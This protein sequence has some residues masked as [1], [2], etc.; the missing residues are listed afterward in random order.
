MPKFRYPQPA[1]SEITDERVWRDRRRLMAAGALMAGGAA[2]PFGRARSESLKPLPGEPSPEFM[3][4]AKITERVHATTYNNFYE[5]GMD[6]SD[7]ERYA[8][9]MKVSP[10]TVRVEG[11]VGKPGTFGIEELLKLEPMQER[12]Y[13][14][15]CV[16]GW[17]MVIPWVGYPLSALLKRVEPTSN[18]KYVEFITDMQPEA[19]P[20][21]S[22]SVIDWPYREG[23]RM[24]EAMN[25]LTL[26][27]FG[28]Y[29]EVLPNQN[30]APVRVIIPW[31]YG[32]KSGKSI[33]TIRLTE[34]QPVSSWMRSA[35]H[36]YGFYANVN[37]EV[38]H[39]RWSQR[40]ERVIGQGLF[41]PRRQTEKF[42]GYQ[43]QVASMYAGM[44]LSKYY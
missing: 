1:P 16:E 25:D 27:T 15:R 8:S 19:M 14:L 22:S 36:E 12:I 32:F 40:T 35:P 43:E 10:W 7:P 18:A 34:K 30:G 28:M 6:K 9:R 44:D 3:S 23:L 39:P 20:G 38:P 33:V 2:L 41:A 42:N 17:S 26:L 11:E 5:F 24:D 31:K 37:P 13:R 4:M 21:L 29:G